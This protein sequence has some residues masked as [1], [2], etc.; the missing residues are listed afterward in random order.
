MSETVFPVPDAWAR[1]ALVNAGEYA[2]MYGMSL[3]DPGSFWLEQARHL[4]WIK[5]PEIAGDWSF[6]EQDFHIQWFADGKLNVA[7]NCI[8]RHL[9]SR[10]DAVAILWEPDDPAEEARRYTYLELYEQVCRFANVLKEQG[11][12]KGDRV[13]VYMPMIPEA[14][15]AILACARIGAIHSVVFGGFSPEAL[16][17]RI[18]D[19]DSTVCITADEGRRGGKRVPLKANVDAAAALAPALEKVLVVRATGGDVPMTPGR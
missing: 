18:T 16:A 17:G 11:V 6:D 15:F 1:D 2:R 7:A 8:D 10:G 19:C 9:A 4:D 14:A 13:T 3:A 5:R 12:R